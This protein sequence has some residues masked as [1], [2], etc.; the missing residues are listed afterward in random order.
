MTMEREKLQE[1]SLVELRR[2]AVERQLP[3]AGRLERGELIDRLGGPPRRLVERERDPEDKKPK[4]AP[5][6]GAFDYPSSTVHPH[7]DELETLTMARRYAAEG[8]A[9]RAL[10]IYEQLAALDPDDETLRAAIADLRARRQPAPQHHHHPA[11]PSEPM[12]MLDLE[13]LPETYGVD[14]CEVMF[15]DPYWAFAYWEVTDAGLAAARAQLGPSAGSARLV[16]RLFTTFHNGN[17]VERELH[18]VDLPWNHG[19]RYLHTPRPGAHLRVA[20]GLL[21]QE[22]YFA[23]VAH[24]SLVRVPNAEPA[25][26]GPVEWM[27]VVPGRSRGKE[28]EPIV[29]VRR[30]AEHSERAVTVDASRGGGLPPTSPTGAPGSSRRS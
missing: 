20:V 3:E 26:P 8:L 1:L 30:G 22:G 7:A 4:R 2:L 21:S 12:W 23:P 6:K 25:A 19:R 5:R 16:L 10:E 15:K 14:E 9:D 24:S 27:E 29:L 13:E 28:R 17:T 18:D 11:P